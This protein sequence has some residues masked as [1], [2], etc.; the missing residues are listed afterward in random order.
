MKRFFL[1]LI[2]L[3]L[4]IQLLNAQSFSYRISVPWEKSRQI[5]EDDKKV[6]LPSIE[7]CG[8]QGQLPFFMWKEKI[9]SSQDFSFSFKNLVYEDFKAEET[10]VFRKLTNLKEVVE[11]KGKTSSERGINYAVIEVVPVIKEGGTYKKLVSFEVSLHPKEGVFKSKSFVTSSVLADPGSRWYKIGVKGDGIHIIT[12]DFLARIGI[13]VSSLNP[14]HIN[15][16]GNANG[17]ISEANNVYR[18]DDLV[19]NAIQVIGEQDGVFDNGDYILFHAYGPNKWK[20]EGNRFVREMN[21]YTETAYYFIRISSSEPPLRIQE[22]VSSPSPTTTVTTYNYADIYEKEYKNLV[23][24]GSTWYGDEFDVDL[25]KNFAFSVPNIVTSVPVNWGI[26]F[27][28]NSNNSANTLVT[29]VNGTT[30]GSVSCGS[31]GSDYLRVESQPTYN[32]TSSSLSVNLSFN[33]VSPS[34]VLYLDKIELNAVRSLVFYGNQMYFRDFNSVGA[35]NVSKFVLS[36]FSQGVEV[37]DVTD[38]RRP[39]KIA[40]NLSGSEFEFAVST[41]TLREFI[42]FRNTGFQTP[43][44]IKEVTTQDLHALDPAKLLIVTHPDYKQQAE[45]LAGLHRSQNTSTHVVTTEEVY[46]EFSSGA[47]DPAAIRWFAKM[48]YD[49]AGGDVSKMP[50]NLLLFGTG[51]YDPRAIVVGGNYVVTYQVKNSENKI[52]ALVADDFFAM[53]DDNESFENGDLLDIGVGRLIASDQVTAKDIVDKIESYLKNTN[54]TTDDKTFGDWRL[55]YVQIA[56]DEA[57]FLNIDCEPQSTYVTTNF[58]EMN[59]DKLY[60]DA[61]TQ[62]VA[63][64]G[65]RYPSLVEAINDRVDRGALVINYVGHGGVYGAA[66]ERFINIPQIQSWQNIDKLNLFVSATC[67]FTRFD[68]PSLRSAGE[69][70]FLNPKGGCIATMTTTRSVYYSVNSTVG[71]RFYENVFTRD[72]DLEPLTFGE[73]IRRTKNATNEGVNK[74]S[75]MLIGDPALK[76]ALPR[77]KIVTDSINLVNP[78]VTQDTVRALSKMRVKGHIE[79]QFG[80][81]MT[82][83]NGKLSPSIFDK[84]KNNVTLNNK[85]GLTDVIPF[86]TQQNVLYKGNVSVQNGYFDFSFIVP[87]DIDYNY[88]NGK[89]SYYADNTLIDASGYDKRFIVGGVDPNGVVDN[90]PPVITMYLND[91]TFVNG[92]LTDENPRLIV[93]LFDENGINAV[94]NGIGHDILAVLD[95][96]TANPIVLNNYYI[97]D[98]DSYQSGKIEYRFS[99][100]P[101]GKHK[102]TF[103]AWDVNNNSAEA[104]IDFEVAE[105]RD[106]ALSHVLNYPNPFTTHTDF[107][108]EHNQVSE[109]LEA[110]VQIF[111]VSG[112]LV[113]TINQLVNTRGY[114]SEGIA[115]DGRDDFGDFIGKGVYVY[116]LTVKNSRGQTAKKIEKLVILK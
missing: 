100:L 107:Y 31:S 34:T 81:I 64:G 51:N 70:N 50:E 15:I 92:G 85:P 113:K 82:S 98:L 23:K 19:K 26:S 74:R 67:E 114:R 20:K 97:A 6:F 63:A 39:S 105:R 104:K 57:Y 12:R 32:A 90:T 71:K 40:G 89:I 48:F 110:Q 86:K 115:W 80:N 54:I 37:W 49:R 36:A 87:K 77:W 10:M 102:L 22:Q 28:S 35:G 58:P 4:N 13:D 44:F 83:Y 33:R 112:K 91:E 55:K 88:G 46:N 30:I 68:D 95:D 43:V 38:R 45:R 79:D 78:S 59:G 52:D 66:D 14:Q 5:M 1:C 94:G 25:S 42:A 106:L 24:G 76:I 69:W 17:K 7:N 84:P 111:T 18:P 103:K 109:P 99:N 29:K 2:L 47:Q 108:F 9:G 116:Q 62:V 27:A 60:A 3:L 41:D 56:D 61:H 73:I 93:K 21:P 101:I 72:A 65:Q 11:L 8:Y 75:F 53:L 16:Y 96:N